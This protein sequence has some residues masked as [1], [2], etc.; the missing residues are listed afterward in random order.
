MTTPNITLYGD[1][2]CP[3]YR[4]SKHFLGKHQIPYSWVDIE[5]D[6]EGEQ[7]KAK[8]L[9]QGVFPENWQMR[10]PCLTRVGS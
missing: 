3:D 9:Y 4:R 5:Q 1:Y 2:W 6:K 8:E 10:Q 7:Q